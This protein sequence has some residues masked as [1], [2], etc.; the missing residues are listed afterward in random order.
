MNSAQELLADKIWWTKKARIEAEQRLLRNSFHLNLLLFHYSAFSVGIAIYYLKFNPESEYI[1]FIWVLFSVL[2][3]CIQ[4]FASGYQFD[5]RAGLLK[6]CY[7][8][9]GDLEIKCKNA[10]DEEFQKV[11]EEY[12]LIL[13]SC[14]NH[15]SI[16]YF[17]AIFNEQWVTVGNIDKKLTKSIYCILIKA[18]LLRFLLLLLLYALPFTL[19]FYSR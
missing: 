16:D 2:I 6:E 5:S 1:N 19:A 17:R 9:L 8:T 3:F 13:R 7:E 12:R 11:I 10:N 18:S 15:L 14:E 4:C